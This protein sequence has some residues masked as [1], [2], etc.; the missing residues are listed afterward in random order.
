[1]DLQSPELQEA[2]LAPCRTRPKLLGTIEGEVGPSVIGRSAGASPQH[3]S[4]LR[5][6]H[7]APAHASLVPLRSRELGETLTRIWAKVP[8]RWLGVIAQFPIVTTAHV[9]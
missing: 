6:Q 2:P 3:H 8:L 1:M 4:Q 7:K 9:G 5:S